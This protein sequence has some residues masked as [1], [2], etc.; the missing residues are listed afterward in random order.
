MDSYHYPPTPIKQEEDLKNTLYHHPSLYP[1]HPSHPLSL[2]EHAIVP[3]REPH[4]PSM[5]S[6][7]SLSPVSSPPITPLTAPEDP[8]IT[9]AENTNLW[10]S[11]SC[12]QSAVQDY[13]LRDP[14]SLQNE[15]TIMI[16]TSKVA[17]K[18]YGTEKRFLCP[19]PST[20]LQGSAWWTRSCKTP[21][22]DHAKYPPKI[23]VHISGEASSQVGMIDWYASGGILDAAESSAAVAADEKSLSGKCVSKQLHISDVDEKRKRVEVNVK[24]QLTNGLYLGTFASQGI[25]VISKPSKKRQSARN[26]ELCIHHGTTVALFNRIRS[27]TVSTKYLC[28]SMGSKDTGACFV[29]RTGSWDPFIIWIADKK[30]TDTS[31]PSQPAS[32]SSAHATAGLPP[33]PAVAL[34]LSS[35]QPTAILYNQAIVLQCVTTG[36]VSPVM[37]IRKADRGSLVQGG[38][39]LGPLCDAGGEHGDEALGDPVSQLHKIAF[40]IVQDPLV[41]ESPP[42]PLPPPPPSSTSNEAFAWSLP[43]TTDPITYLACLNDVV[44]MHRTTTPRMFP[45]C[46]EPHSFVPYC[47]DLL[48]SVVSQENGRAVRK[49]RVSCDVTKSTS[50]SAKLHSSVMAKNRRRVNSLNDVLST[51]F[52]HPAPRRGSHS[53]IHQRLLSSDVQ[54]THGACWTEDVSDAAIWT[55]VGTDCATYT[56][57]TPS[58]LSNTTDIQSMTP[59][60]MLSEK[61]YFTE[62]EG[63]PTISSSSHPSDTTSPNTGS[64]TTPHRNSTSRGNKLVLT[65]E[66]LSSDI[67]VWIGNIQMVT[68]YHNNTLCCIVPSTN[69]LLQSP[70]I[71]FMN[72]GTHHQLPLVLVRNDGVVFKTESFYEF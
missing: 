63:S 25:K 72:E 57:W 60:P 35:D 17:Q 8:L 38:N 3:K 52:E 1:L 42:P 2:T 45:P 53:N 27:Q 64:D 24:I 22:E 37:I 51:D 66:N 32:S 47:Q 54:G 14:T 30:S 4:T 13:L 7:M 62:E 28:V 36:L 49:R 46:F 9:L 19:P 65:G 6:M 59:F 55:I 56:F 26:M 68:E 48:S 31:M 50:M 20:L 70:F 21:R 29:T 43:H 11:S 40:Q 58:P 23:T 69:E 33:P 34:R 71:D 44:G 18:S 41:K 15:H 5:M 10:M 16:L 39:R 67:C 61:V 12:I